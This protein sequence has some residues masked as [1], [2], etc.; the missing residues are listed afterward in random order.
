MFIF[1]DGA[2]I[3]LMLV[4]Y[5]VVIGFAIRAMSPRH[6]ATEITGMDGRKRCRQCANRWG[7]EPRNHSRRTKRGV[8]TGLLLF[9]ITT[10]GAYWLSTQV[11]SPGEHAFGE[12]QASSEYTLEAHTD[13][14]PGVVQERLIGSLQDG[15]LVETTTS[16]FR[17]I[18]SIKPDQ[19]LT[20]DVGGTRDSR[21]IPHNPYAVPSSKVRFY[22][23]DGV[24]PGTFT[25]E[26]E[27]YSNADDDMYTPK[28]EF[29]TE[30]CRLA[31][32]N[33]ALV[34]HCWAVDNRFEPRPIAPEYVLDNLAHY[35]D[36][37]V[38]RVYITLNPADYRQIIGAPTS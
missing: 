16:V 23:D 10:W 38:E 29:R 27:F 3:V 2:F 13:V 35:M 1:N 17:S 14:R 4:I 28:Q 19:T 15:T 21:G 8:V 25:T 18:V 9:A 11:D 34:R 26:F 24:A 33:L 7:L 37:T 6:A 22:Y 32:V 5:G 30:Q 20:I 36:G 31:V 12:P